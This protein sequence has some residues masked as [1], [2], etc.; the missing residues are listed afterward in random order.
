MSAEQTMQTLLTGTAG[1]TALTGARIYSRLVP[2]DIGL[3][4]IAVR[5]L[6]TEYVTTIHENA[7]AAGRAQMEIACMGATV[8]EVESLAS[9]VMTALSAAGYATSN[10]SAEEDI[11]RGTWATLISVGVWE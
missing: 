9:Q 2:V 7:I 4:A 10:R 11:E 8:G 3:P 1:I 6:E 5:R